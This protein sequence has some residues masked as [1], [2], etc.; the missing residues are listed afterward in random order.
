MRNEAGLAAGFIS[1]TEKE[2]R[3]SVRPNREAHRRYSRF[4]QCGSMTI[5]R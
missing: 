3:I 5:E 4:C 2:Q 1:G